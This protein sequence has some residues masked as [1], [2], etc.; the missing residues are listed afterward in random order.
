MHEPIVDATLDILAEPSAA[1]EQVSPA[2]E[3]VL[4]RPARTFAQWAARNIA[5]FR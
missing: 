4:G 3:Q 2:V 5:A 1:E